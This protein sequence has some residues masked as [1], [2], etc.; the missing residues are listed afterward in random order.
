MFDKMRTS[1]AQP[2]PMATTRN[3]VRILEDLALPIE[4]QSAAPYCNGVV[5]YADG[6]QVEVCSGS[7]ASSDDADR[8]NDA[9]AHDSA[10]HA[11]ACNKRE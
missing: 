1:L 6:E 10:D 5:R 9:D 3:A 7:E 11:L 2:H 8:I 4:V